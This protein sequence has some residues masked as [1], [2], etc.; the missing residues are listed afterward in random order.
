[1]DFGFVNDASTFIVSLLDEENKKIYVIDEEYKKGL[2]ND[3]LA[4]MVI[5]KGYAKEVIIADSAEQ[6]SIEEIKRFGVPRIKPAVKG[7]GSIL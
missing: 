1:M 6:K 3:E 2:L 5:K 7:Q 4:Q